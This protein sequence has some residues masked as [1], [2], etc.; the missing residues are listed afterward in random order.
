MSDCRS[1]DPLITPYVDGDIDAAARLRIDDHV[2]ACPPCH[3]RVSAERAVRE[4]M[5]VKRAQIGACAPPEA[6]RA[7]CAAL[8]GGAGAGAGRWR[9]RVKPLAVAAGV[10]LAAGGVF[11]YQATDRSTR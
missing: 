11:V 10:I 9:A 3:S 5:R 4:L 1:I 2:R 8:R 6:L 7:R